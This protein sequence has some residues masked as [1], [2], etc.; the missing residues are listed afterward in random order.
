VK[1]T[2]YTHSCLYIEEKGLKFL[3]DPGIYSVQ[4]GLSTDLFQSLDYLLVTHEH[5][6]HMDLDFIKK[7]TAKFPKII[8]K[9]NSSV[10]NILREKKVN[11][12]FESDDIVRIDEISHEAMFDKNPPLNVAIT[13]LNKIT[14]VGDS[15]RSGITSEILAF[16]IQAPWGSYVEAMRKIIDLKPK[17]IIPIHDWHW[18]DEARIGFYKRSKEYLGQFD[19]SF[20]DL[21]NNE[22]IDI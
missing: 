20:I 8:I 18:K 1:I 9:T 21:D 14:H 7:L 12:S 15:F 13:A 11:A 5:E 22:S 10:V 17:Y 2:K 4:N 6:D 3:F 16:P 19:I